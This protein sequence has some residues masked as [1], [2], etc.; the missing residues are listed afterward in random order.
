[1]NQD[2]SHCFYRETSC[3]RDCLDLETDALLIYRLVEK[4][5]GHKH[6]FLLLAV[7]FLA[8]TCMGYGS[9][10]HRTKQADFLPDFNGGM[11]LIDINSGREIA[12]YRKD[13]IYERRYSPGSLIKVFLLYDLWR[14]GL[15]DPAQKIFC[16]PSRGRERYCWDVAGHKE[17]DLRRA[18]AYSCNHYFLKLAER[19][20]LNSFLRALAAFRIISEEN[21]NPYSKLP[22]EEQEKLM[23]G[24]SSCLQVTPYKILLAYSCIFNG[25]YLFDSTDGKNPG[26]RIHIDAELKNIISQGLRASAINGTSRRAGQEVLPCWL[27]GKTGT[28]PYTNGYGMV[29]NNGA[30]H[31]WFV[32]FI[33][34][35]NPCVGLIVFCEKGN[36]ANDAAVIGGRILHL[37]LEGNFENPR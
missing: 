21:Y 8:L 35:D 4:V 13:V 15:V 31:G 22:R 23:I 18:I 26:T 11:L 37:W 36:G 16:P 7:F 1:M 27:L 9:D 24:D 6:S 2:F 14:Q 20:D 5:M 33:P 32:G 25:G 30:T 17:T 19:E 34:A 29:S 28:S 10:L 3:N 12:S